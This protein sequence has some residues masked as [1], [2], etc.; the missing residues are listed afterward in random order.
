MPSWLNSDTF[1]CLLGPE[2]AG[3]AWHE[4]IT[5]PGSAAL[6][7]DVRLTG[8]RTSSSL[9]CQTGLRTQHWLPA[10]IGPG[11]SS[12]LADAAMRWS[13]KYRAEKQDY[14]QDSTTYQYND[15]WVLW[16]QSKVISSKVNWG[17][18]GYSRLSFHSY[19]ILYI[20]NKRQFLAEWHRPCDYQKCR[21][22]RRRDCG[23]Q[24]RPRARLLARARIGNMHYYGTLAPAR[25]RWA[26]WCVTLTA[27]VACLPRV[28][29]E[30]PGDHSGQ[31]SGIMTQERPMPEYSPSTIIFISDTPGL[32]H[33]HSAGMFPVFVHG[34]CRFYQQ[35]AEFVSWILN[36]SSVWKITELYFSRKC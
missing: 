26:A 15:M 17:R 34:M 12:P 24:D 28:W 16:R 14:R 13:A 29:C 11:S 19:S 30:R 25:P 18:Q 21:A 22:R 4:N 3:W 23:A 9:P 20:S 8:A 7:R 6:A 32:H 33:S 10:M 36:I 35:P 5:V 2:R 1:G 31:L 27:A